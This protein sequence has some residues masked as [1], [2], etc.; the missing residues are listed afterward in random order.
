VEGVKVGL[1]TTVLLFRDYSSAV[2]GFGMSWLKRLTTKGKAK[3][4]DG[5]DAASIRSSS[6]AAGQISAPAQA[7]FRA[8]RHGNE[9]GGA[10]LSF[11]SRLSSAGL[12]QMT[13][14][15]EVW[16]IG[17]SKGNEERRL[18]EEKHLLVAGRFVKRD[19]GNLSHLSSSYDYHGFLASFQRRI[20]EHETSETVEMLYGKLNYLHSGGDFKS[21][22]SQQTFEVALQNL[23]LNR[24]GEDVLTFIFQPESQEARIDRLAKVVGEQSDNFSWATPAPSVVESDAPQISPLAGIS[25]QQFL[26]TPDPTPDKPG[27]Q[28]VGRVQAAATSR[29]VS[30]ATPSKVQRSSV[31]GKGLQRSSSFITRVG[32]FI[33][34]RPSTSEGKRLNDPNISE[35][36]QYSPQPSPGHPPASIGTSLK[37]AIN[38]ATGVT[39][40]QRETREEE[41]ERFKKFPK[42]QRRVTFKKGGDEGEEDG[43]GPS[44][45]DEQEDIAEEIE[46]PEPNEEDEEDDEIPQE[47]RVVA[48]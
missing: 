40:K 8:Q 27:T 1:L 35:V 34:G 33:A 28:Q 11:N 16:R 4:E 23:Y 39:K 24:R 32:G 5:D 7:H 2:I 9:I 26:P 42:E 36:Q 47:D 37:K 15:V 18:K 46:S 44:L 6:G 30:P 45:K 20:N 38:T 17:R 12:D 22:R 21:V 41:R 43:K 48:K 25:D 10:G 29:P 14:A 13:I 31:D 3:E 19:Y